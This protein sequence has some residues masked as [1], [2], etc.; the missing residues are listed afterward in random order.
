MGR[1]IVRQALQA[2]KNCSAGVRN[3]DNAVSS[4]LIFEGALNVHRAERREGRQVQMDI[5]NSLQ[6]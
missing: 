1:D 2:G 5:V 4:E 3:A 6:A